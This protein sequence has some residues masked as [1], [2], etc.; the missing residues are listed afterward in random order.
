[1]DKVERFPSLPI[2]MVMMTTATND[3]APDD[4][5]DNSGGTG[6]D[7]RIRTGTGGDI[8]MRADTGDGTQGQRNKIEERIDNDIAML[9]SATPI[10]VRDSS[11]T[12]RDAD[13]AAAGTIY[14][15][16]GGNPPSETDT[17]L[18]SAGFSRSHLR[19]H[20][21]KAIR[22]KTKRTAVASLLDHSASSNANDEI[23]NRS[24][25]Y[26]YAV[27][28]SRDVNSLPL[29][30]N[31]DIE[32]LERFDEDNSQETRKKEYGTVQRKLNL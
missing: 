7:N 12:K 8:S 5:V 17:L 19:R 26:E 30:A 22:K 3:G 18:A 4:I 23:D 25:F 20:S 13:N 10:V 24:Q 1:L 2:M 14:A 28:E 32:G 27:K 6:D 15:R 21:P 31:D 11:D 9:E 16:T 29:V